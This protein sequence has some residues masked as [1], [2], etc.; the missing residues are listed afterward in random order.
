VRVRDDDGSALLLALG[1]LA[2][3]GVLIPAVLGLATTNLFATQ[4][5]RDQ[6]ATIYAGGGAV[7][8][9]IELVGGNSLYGSF[10]GTCPTFQATINDLA[11][12][13]TC[14]TLTQGV[15][16]DRT[17]QFTASIGGTPKVIA[18][19]LFHDFSN[20]IGTV[21]VLSWTLLS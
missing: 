17:V 16:L 14:Q 5:L 20:P 7:D 9:A 15:D 18:K 4:H 11:T 6:R 13:V 19:V 3:F 1:F 21:S 10:G 2:F 8:G 12:K